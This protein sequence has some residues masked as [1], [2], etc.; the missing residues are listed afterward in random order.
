MHL[1][2][3]ER[4]VI[5]CTLRYGPSMFPQLSPKSRSTTSPQGLTFSFNL[6]LEFKVPE[7]EMQRV[8]STV[9]VCMRVPCVPCYSTW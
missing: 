9:S 4:P 3:M 6:P 8:P 2:K 1:I 5:E 7:R